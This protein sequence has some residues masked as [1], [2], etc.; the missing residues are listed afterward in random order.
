MAVTTLML[1]VVACGNNKKY[2]ANS[3]GDGWQKIDDIEFSLSDNIF[4]INNSPWRE[5]SERVRYINENRNNI[6]VEG[7]SLSKDYTWEKY[8]K[9]RK[10]SI[11]ESIAKKVEYKEV[12]IGNIDAIQYSYFFEA[13]LGAPSRY[14]CGLLF[15]NDDLVYDVSTS[16]KELEQCKERL[17]NLKKTISFDEKKIGSNIHKYRGMYFELNKKIWH[18]VTDRRTYGGKSNNMIIAKTAYNDFNQ[19]HSDEEIFNIIL[20]RFEKLV[21]GKKLKDFEYKKV[22]IDGKEALEYSYNDGKNKY[23]GVNI[24][25]QNMEYIFQIAS[26]DSDLIKKQLEVLK[27]TIKFEEPGI[28]IPLRM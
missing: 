16:D 10:K 7:K 11:Y 13:S 6:F 25:Y 23:I 18:D 26:S 8:V 5:K 27:K 19:V 21:E 12:K 14:T 17:D 1:M 15:A 2:G 22:K 20:N 3:N 24:P 4:S 28:K 9:E